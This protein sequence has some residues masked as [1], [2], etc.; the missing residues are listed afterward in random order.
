MLARALF[1]LLVLCIALSSFPSERTS[2]ENGRV[3][4]EMHNVFYH[5]TDSIYVHIID[6]Q[7]ELVATGKDGMPVFDDA[8]SFTLIIHSAKISIA[9][10]ALTNTLNQHVLA[11]PDAP[12]KAVR[13]SAAGDK[14]RIRGRL[15]SRGDLPF[16]TLGSLAVSPQGEIRVH[17][18]QIKAGHIPIKGLLDLL[19]KTISNLLDT[20]KL[21]GVRTE[22]DDL[23]LTPSELFPPPHIQGQLRAISIRGNEILQEF[24]TAA[25]PTARRPGN[26]MAYRGGYLRFGKLT[27]SN[28]D[29]ILMD[30]DQQDP[31]DFYLDHYI[32]QLVAGYTKTTPDFGLRAYFRDYNKLSAKE[33]SRG[34][35]RNAN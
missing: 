35:G 4:T 2:P 31:F 30:M 11:A 1:R 34:R 17:A 29:L 20:R 22:K 28:T 24:G 18:E 26:Y 13:I 14:L 19:G 3:E 8:S 15:H 12:L 32:D 10:D 7:G 5:F 23:I 21:R 16:E 33:R 27:M 9:T 6:L 25:T